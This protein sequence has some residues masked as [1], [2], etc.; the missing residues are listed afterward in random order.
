MNELEKRAKFNKKHDKGKG[1]FVNPDAGDVEKNVAMFNHASGADSTNSSDAPMSVGEALQA[2]NDSEIIESSVSRFKHHLEAGNPIAIVSAYRAEKSKE[3]N[4]ANDR[5]LK[6]FARMEEVN[7]ASGNVKS[8]FGFVRTAGG[9]AESGNKGIN[10]MSIALITDKSREQELFDFAV[11]MGERYNQ[12]SILFVPSD[13][14]AYYVST[15]DSDDNWVGKKGSKF[16]L[17]RKISSDKADIDSVGGFTQ[18]NRK[19]R[20]INDADT[21][22]IGEDIEYDDDFSI[23]KSSISN[24]VCSNLFKKYIKDYGKSGVEKYLSKSTG[25]TIAESST[26]RIYQHITEDN[27]WAIIS[28]Y[29]DYCSEKENNSRTM[30]LIQDVKMKYGYNM[31]ESRWVWYDEESDSNQI[32]KERALLIPNIP[33][34]EAFALGQKYNQQSIIVS[35]DGQCREVCTTSYEYE[36]ENGTVHKYSSGDVIRTFSLNKDKPLSISD[37]EEIFNGSKV[38]PA[39]M[40]IKGG[41]AFKLSEVYEVSLPRP[42]YFQDTVSYRKIYSR[43]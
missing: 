3:E 41:K 21:F 17:G 15:N 33:F 29:R 26:S 36:D 37:A 43:N 16:Y 42:S 18:V 22:V 8:L 13:G 1:W 27:N 35:N 31:F 34:K 38:G 32:S 6:K 10:E 19:K 5:E 40:P 24:K 12:D 11:A 39:S 25:S 14:D 20:N 2:L 7:V 9:Y 4:E 28:A 30:H 23:N